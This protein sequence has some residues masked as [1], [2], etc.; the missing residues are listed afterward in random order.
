MYGYSD[1][2]DVSK[3]DLYTGDIQGITRL[4]G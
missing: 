4:Y 3:R 2:G 1:F